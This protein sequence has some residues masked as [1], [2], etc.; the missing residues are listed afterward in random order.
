LNQYDY[1]VAGKD[2]SSIAND[3]II[4]ELDPIFTAREY[5]TTIGKYL[6]YNLMNKYLK[7]LSTLYQRDFSIDQMLISCTFQ[8]KTCS[9][10]DFMYHYD[11]YFGLCWRY[12]MGRN[13]KGITV[14]I[15]MI[16]EAG[17]RNGL[18]LELYVGH[19]ELQEKYS[20]RRGFRVL[21]FNKSTVYPVAED[22]GVDVATGMETNIGVR[23]T[24][25]THL[26]APFSNCL[27]IDTSQIDWS[28][29][30]ALNFMFENYVAGQYYSSEGFW[31]PAGNW[32]WNWTVSYSQSI[33]IKLCFQKSLFK[34]CGIF[35][36]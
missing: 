34:K 36:V 15:R 12:N 7:N 11:F 18:Q 3:G 1:I 22:I 25:T 30:D 26:P 20:T 16:G 14:P 5:A 23:R 19:A 24:F 35:F 9:I 28:Q 32:T 29:N 8:G 33:C 17:F 10:N 4:R 21:V 2:L 13:L 27:P 31:T 6:R